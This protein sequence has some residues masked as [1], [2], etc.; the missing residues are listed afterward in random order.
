MQ[1]KTL[2]FFTNSYP[3]NGES[4]VGNE[5]QA[6]APLYDKIKLFSSVNGSL[7]KEVLPTNVELVYIDENVV[8][9]PELLFSNLGLICHV[10]WLDFFNSSD[11]KN[12]FKSW[13]YN[14]SQLLKVIYQCKKLAT[15]IES[16][17]SHKLYVSFW[18]DQWALC[19]SVLKYKNRIQSFVYRVHQHDLYI[20][21]NP[22]Q[23]IPFRFFNMKMASGI[24]PDAKRGVNYLKELNYYSEKVHLG[25]LGVF[26]KGT[27]PFNR[28]EF[29]IVSCSA[30]LT[31]KRVE[32]IADVLSSVNIP[33]TW[34]HFGRKGE[35]SDAFEKL[36]SKCDQLPKNIKVILKG[37]VPYTEL[38]EF[39]KTNSVNLFVTLTRSEGLPVSV[40]EA[41]SFGI[42]V[43]ATDVM[44][45]PDVVT[46]E[47]GIIVKPDLEMEKIAEEI[48]KFA[49]GNKN[50][51]EFR[52]TTK[53]F[54]EKNF[55][56]EVNY[57]KFN[58]FINN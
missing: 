47:S 56:A 23:Y 14:L 37:D 30:L 43:L 50:T 4:F 49:S 38:L 40:I 34:I 22:Q 19:L 31:R 8:G 36:K 11:K 17:T 13:R 6:L 55:K 12:F 27:N 39:Y 33:L 25:H 20:D 18:M 29:T 21:N 3:Y 7:G 41:V 15:I 9:K 44:G 28:D 54:W 16:D 48:T 58:T 35:T 45:L 5:I 24:F 2:Y 51:Q 10:F 42:P 1:G 26:D 57:A 46:D 52:A 53:K 32:S